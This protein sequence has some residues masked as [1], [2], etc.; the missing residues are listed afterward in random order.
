MPW[1]IFYDALPIWEIVANNTVWVVLILVLLACLCILILFL[2]KEDRNDKEKAELREQIDYYREQL[3]EEREKNAQLQQWK[4]EMLEA[5]Q[6]RMERKSLETEQLRH[7]RERLDAVQRRIERERVEAAK[8]EPVITSYPVKGVFNHED[9]I[10]HNLMEYN[11]L[12][13]YTKTE[14][15]DF[16]VPDDPVYKWI[17]KNLPAVLIPEPENK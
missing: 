11:P 3:D 13:D 4:K 6:N 12:Y 1:A 10:F 7:V 5:E 2:I 9:D 8:P 17:P 14:I 15:I 16:C